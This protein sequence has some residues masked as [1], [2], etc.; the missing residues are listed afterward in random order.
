[1]IK[2]SKSELILLR[3]LDGMAVGVNFPNYFVT[4][5]N[6][7]TEK[8]I[9]SFVK[10]GLLT[11]AP[12]NY[13]I[14]KSTASDIKKIIA[15]NNLKAAG[16][17]AI[18]IQRL[19]DNLSEDY[20]KKKFNTMF[21]VVSQDG[22]ELLDI[23]LTN[24]EYEWR[25]NNFHIIKNKDEIINL[26]VKSNFSKAIKMLESEGRSCV[27]LHQ[28]NFK[29]YCDFYNY[30][31][32]LTTDLQLLEF[33]IK[34]HII[35]CDMIGSRTETSCKILHDSGIDI[36]FALVHKLSRIIKS[37]SEL[38]TYRDIQQYSPYY[39]IHS[40]CDETVCKTCVSLKGLKLNVSDAVIGINFPPMNTCKSEYCRCYASLL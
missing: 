16:T 2:L 12:L 8:C 19:F 31:I 3:Y 6:L 4:T 7:N 33:D 38:A 34:S 9:K 30:D 13:V 27:P 18:L 25:F 14:S 22:N 35:M 29:P 5:H 10:N 1:M 20:L 40:M 39:E 11:Y 28:E 26:I 36:S 37:I 15:E 21:Y 24:D 32:K 23:G 17:K